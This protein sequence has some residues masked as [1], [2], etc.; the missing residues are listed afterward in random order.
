MLPDNERVLLGPGPSMISPR[1]MRALGAPMLSHLD[2][3]FLSIMDDLRARLTRVFQADDDAFAFAV[4]GTGT[5]A[6][7]TAVANLVGPDT[8]VLSIVSG[9]FGARIADMCRRYGAQVRTLDVE[10]G[11][12]VDPDAVART[13]RA[14]RADVV[15]VVHAETS[16]GVLNPVEGVARAAH[17]HDAIVIVDA[18]TSLGAMPLDVGGWKLDA[19][20]SCS[21]KGLGAPSG[22]APIVFSKTALERRVPCRSFYFDL[23]LLQ[24]YWTSRKYHHTMCASLIYALREALMVVEEEGLPARWER[25]ERHHHALVQGLDARGLSLLPA[26]GERLWTLNAIRVPEGVDEGAVRRHLFEKYNIEIGAGLGPLAGRI[27][28]VGLMGTSSTLA[29]VTLFLSAIEDALA[30]QP[31]KLSTS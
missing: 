22:V 2:P 3:Q 8:R 5:S 24:D 13:L 15:T 18:V 28:R 25:H 23:R 21:Q 7:E 10:W 14:E 11:R 6:M 1:V 26:P 12:A 27:W 9:Y 19:V 29:L 31:A 20:Y 30:A 16:T 4:S 17:E